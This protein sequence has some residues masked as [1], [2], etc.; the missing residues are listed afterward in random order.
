MHSQ[1][2][3]VAIASAIL[4]SLATL[5]AVAMYRIATR[6]TPEDFN[7]THAGLI[8]ESDCYREGQQA[9][10]LHGDDGVNPYS[11]CDPI[12]RNKR[13]M[14]QQGFDDAQWVNFVTTHDSTIG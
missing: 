1:L 11:R 6:P 2:I 8:I 4:G 3:T 5:F 12:T 10:R 14:W 13:E 9:F 7:D